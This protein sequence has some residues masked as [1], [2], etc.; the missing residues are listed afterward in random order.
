VLVYWFDDRQR[1]LESIKIP[2][3]NVNWKVLL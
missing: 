2:V 1:R 3:Y